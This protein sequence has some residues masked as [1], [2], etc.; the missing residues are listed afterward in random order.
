MQGPHPGAGFY[1]MDVAHRNHVPFA[2]V[3]S[4]E[5]AAAW[6]LDRHHL[7]E[8]VAPAD[9]LDVVGRILGLHAQVMSSAE[10]SLHVRV[11]GLDPGAVPRLLWE[12]RSLYKTWAMRGTLHL[13]P[14]RER[15]FWNGALANY[16]HFT[17]RAWLKGWGVTAEQLQELLAVVDAELRGGPLSRRELAEAVGRRA[18]ALAEQAGESWGSFLKPSAF[19]G[20]LC[21]APS[22]GQQVRFAHP[23]T[24]LGPVAAE[25]PQAAL[26]ELV[27][28]YLGSYGPAT[29]EDLSRWWSGLTVAG[30]RRMLEEVAAPVDVGGVAAYLLEEDLA[31]A[32][33]AEPTGTLRLLPAFD[34]YVAGAPRA[35]H[36]IFP[37]ERRAEIY[38]QAGWLTPVIVLDGVIAGTFRYDRKGV[39]EVTP[40][41][42]LPK[43]KLKEE[44][45]R[46]LAV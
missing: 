19:R 41:R 46:F 23:E 28:R 12:E 35:G 45:D 15:A 39:G 2:R 20:E 24:W 26:R 34:P 7:R 29:P 11:D 14:A 42:R 27:R 8:R 32:A 13:L 18:P 5:Q 40:W 33:A 36:W 38:R 1:Y 25:E 10:L 44:T 4:F 17:R 21:F 6:R 22:V 30:A 43:R 16:D 31:E 3:L 9:A 37:V